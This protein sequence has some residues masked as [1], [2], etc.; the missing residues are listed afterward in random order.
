VFTTN[1]KATVP[2]YG[3]LKPSMDEDNH[4]KDN[5]VC[6]TVADNQRYNSPPQLQR[7]N[8]ARN[9]MHA[10]ANPT[11]R[12]LKAVLKMSSIRNSPVTEHDIDMAVQI[13]DPN[14]ASL[15]RK[16]LASSLP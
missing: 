13:Y 12:D 6:S 16:P 11:V 2:G 8:V 7:A 5:I 1:P 3:L 14:V 4:R 10:L 9:L 15:K